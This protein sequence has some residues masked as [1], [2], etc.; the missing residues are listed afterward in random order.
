MFVTVIVSFFLQFSLIMVKFLSSLQL[1]VFVFIWQVVKERNRLV[2][3]IESSKVIYQ[4]LR[5]LEI[6][7]VCKRGLYCIFTCQG[8]RNLRLFEEGGT[9]RE[10][11]EIYQVFFQYEENGKRD[12]MRV[13][14]L[15][16]FF[17]EVEGDFRRGGQ[18]IAELKVVGV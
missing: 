7:R 11:K 1:M 2:S 12:G 9:R 18:R 10:N 17:C 8:Q 15:K 13:R 3:R 6:V 16:V 5:F 4:F 14:G